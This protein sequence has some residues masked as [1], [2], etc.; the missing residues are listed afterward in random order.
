MPT[1]LSSLGRGAKTL[2]V[3]VLLVVALISANVIA[4]F[5]PLRVDI[6]EDGLYTLSEGT[7]RI[8]DSLE[9]P[10]TIKYYFSEDLPDVPIAVKNYHR[11]V[12]ELLEAYE[13]ASGGRLV[14]QTYNPEPDS[15]EEV[16]A[17]RYG[18]SP[19]TLGQ[20]NKLY[21]GLVAL[22]EDREATLPFISTRREKFLEYDI[23][24][25]ITRVNQT[26]QPKLGVLSYLPITGQ[27]NNPMQ[28]P[29]GAWVVLEE[30]RKLYDL[31]YLSS[32]ATTLPEG[33]SGVILVHPRRLTPGLTYALDQFLL[34]GGRLVALL[35]PN[36]R[37]DPTASGPMGGLP[38]GGSSLEHLFE[39][40]GITHEKDRIVGDLALATQVTSP[41]DGVIDFPLWITAG[42]RQMNPDVVITSN[43]EEV[44]LVDTGAFGTTDKFA[45]KFQ[46]LITT[47]K[48][49]GDIDNMLARFAGPAELT[50]QLSPDGEPR[51]VAAV[52]SG[53]FRTAYP[54]GPPPPEA[55]GD[56]ENENE[57]DKPPPPSKPH[58]SEGE[59]DAT[60]VLIGDADFIGDP[61]A[62]QPV[63]FFGQQMMQPINDNLSFFLNAVEY[64]TGNQNLIAIRSRGQFSRPFTRVLELQAE[65]QRKYQQEEQ[66]LTEKLERVR[67]QLAALEGQRRGEGN[68]LLT[69]EAV[70]EIQKYR[71]EEQRTRTALREVRR[72]LRQ[73]IE[74][75]GNRLLLFNLLTIPIV[76]ALV[77]SVI[78]YRRSKRKG[79]RR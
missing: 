6:T 47:T 67:K 50:R 39:A 14:L 60:V 63:N 5:L 72:E 38:G 57:E 45:Y 69:P 51:V 64:A 44:V 20:G 46:P 59:A 26:R 75:L 29:Q 40:W 34:R 27:S 53:R 21:F 31:E 77:G 78:I 10:V 3:I 71:Q 4:G 76:V 56:N 35:D 19:V 58:L 15:D 61:F 65:A 70:Q 25:V 9:N 28:Q 12:V 8:L 36:A 22:S 62:V 30:L 49:S 73:D 42:P 7:E 13:A 55:D 16:W 1:Q 32:D 33:L 41:Q 43:L 54:D 17:E 37:Q 68:V 52:V 74:A 2:L 23:S 18:L 79:G 66:A 48:D 11:K 24:E